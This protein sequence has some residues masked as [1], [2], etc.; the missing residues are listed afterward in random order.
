MTLAP[1]AENSISFA[2]VSDL[3][4]TL[5]RTS[6]TPTCTLGTIQC[7]DWRAFT[8]EPPATGDH[9]AIPPGR[10][11]IRLLWSPRFKRTVPTL[12]DVPGRSHILIHPGNESDDTEGCILL[13]LQQ[14]DHSVLESRDAVHAFAVKLSTHLEAADDRRAYLI[15]DQPPSP[16]AVPTTV[17]A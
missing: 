12:I 10:Y 11:E 1:R 4:F 16:F 2:V 15:V 13:G 5:Q 8:L 9:P 7:G 14:T 6:V 3:I 17:N